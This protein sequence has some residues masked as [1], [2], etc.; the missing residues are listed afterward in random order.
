V[1]GI[2]GRDVSVGVRCQSKVDVV[3]RRMS[4]GRKEAG[5]WEG[6]TLLTWTTLD[7]FVQDISRELLISFA[8]FV[9]VSFKTLYERPHL[10]VV[11]FP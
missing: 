4:R 7:I 9:S 3:W 2:D 10:D 1:V 11:M 5:V 6:A 8:Y